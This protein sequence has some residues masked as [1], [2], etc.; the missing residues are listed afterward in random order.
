MIGGGASYL[1]ALMH[2][3]GRTTFRSSVGVPAIPCWYDRQPNHTETT[4]PPPPV[5]QV[6]IAPAE[7]VPTDKQMLQMVKGSLSASGSS[8]R[9]H[10]TRG[11]ARSGTVALLFAFPEP[12][13]V[14][15]QL[16]A[17][18]KVIGTGMKTSAT[19]G[20]AIFTL[21]LTTQGRALLK[22]SKKLTVTMNA[23][24]APSRA[25]AG[26]QRASTK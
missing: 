6:T 16:L 17:K 18:H 9:S 23:T 14:D 7:L 20:K 26:P 25:G 8:L 1:A 11:L 21:R 12:G 3:N 2:Q 24:F 22:R 5:N 13:S 19:N 4:Q 10:T 15:L